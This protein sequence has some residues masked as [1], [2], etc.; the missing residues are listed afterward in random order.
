MGRGEDLLRFFAWFYTGAG[1]LAFGMQV[2]VSRRA[3]R[4]LGLARSVGALPAAT[5]VGSAR[6]ADHRTVLRLVSM[7]AISCA[8]RR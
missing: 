2:L 8:S 5:A 1:L 4:K 7:I 6:V 3:L